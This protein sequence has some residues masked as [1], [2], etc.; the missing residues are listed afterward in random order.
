MKIVQVNTVCGI[1]STGRIA[2]DL[3]HLIEHHGMNP[4]LAYGREPSENNIHKYRIGNRFDFCTHVFSNF[5]R[6]NSGFASKHVTGKFLSWLDTI[7]PDLLHLHNLHG[8]YLNIELL[9]DYIKKRNVPVV[10]TLHDC[11]SFTGQCAHFDY[12]GCSKWKS[13][14]YACPIY[15]SNY[16]YSLF[17]DNSEENY[18]RKKQ[19]F[20][21]VKNLTIVTPSHW[22]AKLVS[23][24][25]LKEYPIKVIPNGIDLDVFSPLNLIT[26]PKEKIILGVAN[27]WSKRKGIDD[28]F[29]LVNL[30]PQ[31]Y[32][33]ILIGVSH[34]QAKMINRRFNG[35]IM[36]ITRTHNVL[37]L[38]E[39]YRSAYVFVNPTYEDN[40]PT[41]NLEALACGTPV[42]TYQTGGS[43][44]SITPETGIVVPKGNVKEL[45]RA[46]LSLKNNRTI[47]SQACRKHA[48][49]Y[50]KGQCFS[51][52]ITLYKDLL[53]R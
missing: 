43:P 47:S 50:E 24:S 14:C 52:Y 10:W 13:Q 37:Q 4:Y 7:Q 40:F 12:V 11:W 3:Y 51:E 30:L 2:L 46:I 32:K 49:Q 20:C 23:E 34:K 21:G 17:C 31:E 15:K 38:V 29:H 27:V 6:G 9:F 36:G 45:A 26:S 8:F 25:F 33:V 5:F 18:R 53:L 39:Y 35:H 1:G 42:I 16:P 48:M 22:L 19:A 44:E 41:T 28:F